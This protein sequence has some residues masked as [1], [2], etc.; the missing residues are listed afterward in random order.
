MRITKDDFS[1]HDARSFLTMM[2]SILDNEELNK[3]T[4][5]NK[6]QNLPYMTIKLF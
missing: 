4:S 5:R 6:L 3:D 1:F 2:I